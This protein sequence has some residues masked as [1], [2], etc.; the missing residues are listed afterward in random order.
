MSIQNSWSFSRETTKIGQKPKA[1][2]QKNDRF[3]QY[4][5]K[6]VRFSMYPVKNFLLFHL[7]AIY[8]SAD[9]ITIELFTISCFTFFKIFLL[10]GL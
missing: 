3:L 10:S 2:K 8:E 6:T 4:T 1:K 7:Y 5:R 9:F